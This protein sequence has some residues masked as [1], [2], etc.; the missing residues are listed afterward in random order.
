MV[1]EVRIGGVASSAAI[2]QGSSIVSS[3]AIASS[4][5]GSGTLA[6]GASQPTAFASGPPTTQTTSADRRAMTSAARVGLREGTREIEQP[7][8]PHDKTHLRYLVV[9]GWPDHRAQRRC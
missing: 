3:A 1:I 6:T 5:G 2:A 4:G 7:A 9:P 8:A